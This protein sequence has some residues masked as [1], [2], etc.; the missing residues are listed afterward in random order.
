MGCGQTSKLKR[1]RDSTSF[2]STLL[3]QNIIW[4][5]MPS[6]PGTFDVIEQLDNRIGP[7]SKFSSSSRFPVHLNPLEPS[8]ADRTENPSPYLSRPGTV[9]G[10][11]KIDRTI[12]KDNTGGEAA[13]LACL[14]AKLD[15]SRK[16]DIQGHFETD[17][18]LGMGEMPHYLRGTLSDNKS[19]QGMPGQTPVTSNVAQ[20]QRILS[21]SGINPA[22]LTQQQFAVFSNQPPAVQAKSIAT[23]AANLQQHQAS[24]EPNSYNLS[25]YQQKLVDYE[26]KKGPR[27][28][29]SR[30]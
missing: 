23:Y 17:K 21:D 6:T 25:E 13:R 30:V 3:S 14:L 29:G 28:L 5:D 9:S 27:Y 19:P 15:T 26:A 18:R 2:Q 8:F 22:S 16:V 10:S 4:S 11:V 12:S 24:Q 7:A 20:A 1:R